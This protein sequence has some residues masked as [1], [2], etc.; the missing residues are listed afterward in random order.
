MK[1][2]QAKKVSDAEISK[3]KAIAAQQDAELK[4]KQNQQ[5]A[6]FGGLFLLVVFLGFVYNRFRVTNSQKK[7]IERQK[8]EVEIQKEV[9]ELAHTELEEK[10]KEILDSINYAKRIQSAI[11]PQDKLIKENLPD[12]FILYQPKDIVAG[13][14]YWFEKKENIILIAAADC[15]GHGVP[16]ALVS[17]VC[18]GALNRAVREFGLTQPSHILNKTREIVLSEFEKSAE[19]VKDGMDISLCAID[20]KNKKLQWAGANNPLWMI[21]NDTLVEIKADKQPIGKFDVI[22]D[23]TNHEREIMSGDYL[24]LITDG[25]ADQFGGPKSKKFK[26]SNLQKLLLENTNEDL[27]SLKKIMQSTFENWKGNLE[28]VDDVT[29]IGIRI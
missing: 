5:Y 2:A 26:Y 3:Q 19:D 28:Q 10:N 12:S 4:N 14:F 17:V 15:T 18:H 6:L 21:R 9:V 8:M 29:L 25:F 23:F 13:D 20:L 24:F 11:L 27:D 1:N 22:K 16:G 7:I